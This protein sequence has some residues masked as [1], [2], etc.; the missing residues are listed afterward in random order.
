[1]TVTNE[2]LRIEL[3]DSATGTFLDSGSAKISGDGGELG[4]ALALSF[5]AVPACFSVLP[6]A[7]RA[8]D[9][10]QPSVADAARR[11]RKEQV[12]LSYWRTRS[13]TMYSRTMYIAAIPLRRKRA[14]EEA[15]GAIGST[16]MR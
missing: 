13:R 10:P 8:Q 4:V 12:T 2:G 14:A 3:T 5:A 7:V 9:A 11:A 1:M 16:V 6:A 15:L